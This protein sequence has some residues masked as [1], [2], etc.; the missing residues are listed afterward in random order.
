M[1][2][3]VDKVMKVLQMHEMPYVQHENALLNTRRK[4]NFVSVLGQV[5]LLVQMPQGQ[6]GAGSVF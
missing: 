4:S 6:S 1:S 3:R 2:W 5:A